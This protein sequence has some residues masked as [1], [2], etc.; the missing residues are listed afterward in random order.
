MGEVECNLLELEE[1]VELVISDKFV[2]LLDQMKIFRIPNFNVDAIVV[3]LLVGDHYIPSE[4]QN[5]PPSPFST[6]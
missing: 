4:R 1:L 3:F 2:V 5:L 6:H